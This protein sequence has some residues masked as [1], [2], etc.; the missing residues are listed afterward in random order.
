MLHHPFDLPVFLKQIEVERVTYTIAPPA[1]LA[2][3][4]NQPELTT[5]ADI[6]SLRAIGSGSAPL[7][8]WLIQG[9][10]D[11]HSIQICNIFGSNEGTALVA[12]AS[13]VSDPA[14]RARYFP[15]YGAR[16]VHWDGFTPSVMHT[17]LVDPLSGEEIVE[18]G[19]A[20]ELRISGATVFPG[21]WRA[22]ELTRA[23]FDDQGYFRTGDLFEIAGPDALAR[24]YRFVG[25]C[26]EIIVRGG[27]NISPAGATP[28]PTRSRRPW[29]MRPVSPWPCSTA[30]TPGRPHDHLTCQ[31]RTAGYRH[32]RRRRRRP[33]IEHGDT[34]LQRKRPAIAARGTPRPRS[35][36]HHR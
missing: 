8:A 15:R 6:S 29:I 18:P 2:M 27:V 19:C 12:S 32:T 28:R 9:W 13:D 1:V 16:D 3:L 17:R 34:G 21:Y 14:E 26:K 24:Y 22:P 35:P 23:A 31:R 36:H 4:L 11:K 33:D 7:S 25:R 30:G 5:G 20:G 10:L